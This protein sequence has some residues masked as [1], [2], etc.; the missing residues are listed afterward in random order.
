MKYL[1]LKRR[2]ES[3]DDPFMQM[4][5][6][7]STGDLQL[8]FLGKSQDL[9]DRDVAEIRREPDTED[10]IPSILF[11]LV[12]PLDE[13]FAGSVES[14]AWGLDAVGAKT[15]SQDGKGVTVA[16]LDTGIDKSHPAFLGM[17]FGQ[18]NLM[19]F[20]VYEHGSLGSADDVHGHGTH[21]AGTIFGRSVNGTR[22]GV[23]PGVE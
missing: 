15:S 4:V 23:A 10:V 1:I 8:P 9:R 20:T 5:A 19:D 22:I 6:A 7:G 13:T 18:E 17:R 2:R 14:E 16:V 3:D 12:K 11:T 21:V